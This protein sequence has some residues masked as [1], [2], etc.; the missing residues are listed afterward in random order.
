M[1]QKNKSG[2]LF[3]KIN[4]IDFIVIVA[5]IIAVLA[6]GVSKLRSNAD[7]TETLIMKY[8]VEEVNSNIASHVNVGDKLYDGTDK[9]DLGTV[10]EVKTDESVS[11]AVKSDG[12]YA[13]G[14]KDG[15][16]SLIITG[17]VQGT[18]TNLGAT[19][20]G[21][22]YG[23]GHSFMLVAGESRIYLRVYDIQVKE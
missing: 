7:S 8:Y 16:C 12:T 1:D 3:G 20:G 10:T 21:N 6:I 15:Y 17:E 19:V 14:G 5:V 2:K 13:V 18:K 11:Y 4:I 9:V 22:K 23:V